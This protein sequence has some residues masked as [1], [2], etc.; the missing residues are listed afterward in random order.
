MAQQPSPSGR[1][2]PLGITSFWPSKRAEPPMLWE[3]CVNRL[4]RGMIAKHSIHPKNFYFAS[5]PKKAD[6]DE[7]AALPAQLILSL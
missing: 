4:Q 7:K 5:T 6:V 3:F 2:N 1:K